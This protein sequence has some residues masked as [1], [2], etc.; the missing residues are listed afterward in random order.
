MNATEARLVARLIEATGHS[1]CRDG[2]LG[3]G[4]A[5]GEVRSRAR[6]HRLLRTPRTP[7]EAQAL[8]S[9]LGDGLILV[10]PVPAPAPPA[11]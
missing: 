3:P 8:L 4:V 2:A 10:V 5:V 7:A 1:R 11:A 9:D 6:P